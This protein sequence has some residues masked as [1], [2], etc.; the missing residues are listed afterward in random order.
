MMMMTAII[1]FSNCLVTCRPKS[2]RGTNATLKN[3]KNK[4]KQKQNKNNTHYTVTVNSLLQKA[5]Q[6]G[7]NELWIIECHRL[8]QDLLTHSLP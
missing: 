7:K 6:P 8:V 1:E 5:P 3:N 4:R 2:T